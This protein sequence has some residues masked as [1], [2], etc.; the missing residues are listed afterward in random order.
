LIADGCRIGR[1]VRI[2]NS[3]VGLRCIIGENATIRN[4]VLMGADEYETDGDLRDD[5]TRGQPPIGIGAGA[6][7][8]GAI[9]DKNCRIGSGVRI[10][11]EPGWDHQDVSD[12]CV[13]R[14]GIPVV[15]KG[16]TLS[17]GWRLNAS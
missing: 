7:V 15:V 12:S 16:S 1:K 17:D 9:V 10:V 5:H 6:V 8:E 2:E 4:S 11:N 3:V 14:D 13:V